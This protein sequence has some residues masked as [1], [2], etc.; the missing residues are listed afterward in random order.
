MSVHQLR[1]EETEHR[2]HVQLSCD[3]RA[4]LFVVSDEQYFLLERG[5][6]PRYPLFRFWD[7]ELGKSGFAMGHE[8]TAL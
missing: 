2:E 4:Q 6:E 3:G 5:V 1:G 8:S 7:V